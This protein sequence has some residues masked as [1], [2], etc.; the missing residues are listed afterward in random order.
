MK[1]KLPIII[2]REYLNIVKKTSFIVVTLLGPIILASIFIIP[3]YISHINEEQTSIG[4][5]DETGF[6]YKGLQSNATAKYTLLYLPIDSAKKLLDKE[7]YDAILYIPSSFI[8]SPETP[9]IWSKNTVSQSVMDNIESALK[10]ELEKHRLALYGINNQILEEI[11]ADVRVNNYTYKGGVEKAASSTVATILGFVMAIIIY[12]FVFMYGSMVLRS[13]MEEK[14]NRIVEVI[15]SSVKSIHLLIGKIV[16]VLLVGLTQF[17]TWIILTLLIIIGVQQAF[18]DLFK[19]AEPEAIS[20]QTKGLN[21]AEAQQLANAAKLQESPTNNALIA[22]SNINIPM[23]ILLFL[24]YFIFGY[25]I[26]STM[27]AAIGAAVDNQD[28][29]NQFMLPITIPLILAIISLQP[30]INNP[31]GGVSIFFSLF[32]L[33]SPVVMMGLIPFNPPLW[34]VI[35]SMI[36][37]VLTF[38][39]SAFISAKIY[40]IGILTYGKRPSYKELWNWIK[41]Y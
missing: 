15:I 20:I 1:N 13:V 23:Y 14:L 24:F 3:I 4:V 9:R 27:F 6:I 11:N 36:I 10:S 35:T 37:L 41:R 33:T 31:T 22:L 28:D 34:L 39:L 32:P 29:T 18:P 21:P 16:A 12:F 17:I 38:L 40:R 25:L 8:N 30:I 2:K 5:V 26:Y 7:E 19:Y